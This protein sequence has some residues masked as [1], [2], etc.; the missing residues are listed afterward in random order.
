MNEEIWELQSVLSKF[1]EWEDFL[2]GKDRDEWKD[3]QHLTDELQEAIDSAQEQLGWAISE[4]REYSFRVEQLEDE[5]HELNDT[6]LDLRES[7]EE[8]VESMKKWM[9]EY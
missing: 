4:A 9:E 8:M 1:W 2:Q 3:F 6:I 7:R 5:V